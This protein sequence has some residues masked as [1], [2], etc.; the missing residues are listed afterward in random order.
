MSIRSNGSYIGFSRTTTL[1]QGSASGIWDLRTAERRRLAN[2]WPLPALNP[3]TIAGLEIWLDAS[4]SATLYDATSGGSL[5]ASG[6]AVAR[7]EDKS[8][9]A[10]HATQSDSSERPT[11]SVS[12]INGLDAILFDGS[13]DKMFYSGPS[14]SDATI[15]AVVKRNADSNVY[16]GVFAFAKTFCIYSRMS[17]DQWGVYNVTNTAD[18]GSGVSLTVGSP[19]VVTARRTSANRFLYTNGTLSATVSADPFNGYTDVIGA[20]ADN[21]QVH[22]GYIGEVLGYSESLS[23]ANRA[24]VESYLM[25][26]WGV[27]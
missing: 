6:S 22:R 13:D 19:F 4:D 14:Q 24:A 7:W 18:N 2:A 27:S 15:F 3:T 1:S 26:K 23:D 20:D 8:G 16:A 17:S 12:E 25:Q 21:A 9:K 10:R 11:R 5:V